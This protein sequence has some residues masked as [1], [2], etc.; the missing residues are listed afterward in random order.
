MIYKIYDLINLL[1][2]LYFLNNNFLKLDTFVFLNNI[3]KTIFFIIHGN[4][5]NK[6]IFFLYLHKNLKDVIFKLLFYF[7]FYIYL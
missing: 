3:I 2:K 4:I 7:L 1:K 6:N 5:I